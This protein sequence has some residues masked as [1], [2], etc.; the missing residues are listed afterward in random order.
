MSERVKHVKRNEFEGST[1]GE[2]NQRNQ[3]NQE[4]PQN[5]EIVE[6]EAE[7]DQQN[8]SEI[9]REHQK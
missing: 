1:N 9:R 5:L 8:A 4:N 6:I 3:A 2:K 7:Y